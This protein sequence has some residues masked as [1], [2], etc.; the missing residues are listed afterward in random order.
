MGNYDYIN[1]M[2]PIILF[3]NGK[4]RV[5]FQRKN[6]G[7]FCWNRETFK[8]KKKMEAFKNFLYESVFEQTETKMHTS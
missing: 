4:K 6:G 5:L 8:M 1:D 3:I 2:F 7:L